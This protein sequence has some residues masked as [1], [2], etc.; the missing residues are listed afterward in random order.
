MTQLTA[1]IEKTLGPIVRAILK[2]IAVITTGGTI[3]SRTDAAGAQVAAVPGA[4]LLN[5]V[6]TDEG[7]IVEVRD[8]F[9]VNSYALTL[10][11]MDQ[12]RWAVNEALLEPQ[13]QGVV[14]A[15][16]TD[17]LEETA[18]LIELFHSDSRPVVFTG[19]Q[20]SAD[21]LGN[22]GP[23]NLE[24][25]IALAASP[26]AM[27]LGVLIMFDGI[28][29]SARGARKTHTTALAAFSDPDFGPLGHWERGELVLRSRPV[30]S[31]P[32]SFLT[33]DFT[34]VHVDIVSLYPGVTSTAMDAYVISGARGLVL[35]ATGTGNAN[36][37]IAAA[38]ARHVA[39]GVQ[40]V[41]STRVNAGPIRPVYGG[42]G[43]GH[44]LIAAGA[45]SAGYLRPSQARIQLAS[46]LACRASNDQILHSFRRD[47]H[48]TEQTNPHPT[49][50]S[51]ELS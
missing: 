4:D 51:K 48:R 38:V 29:H 26:A 44:D 28:V 27:D 45:I 16:G 24:D 49:T 30:R 2:R 41:L 25:A 5:S 20:R 15:H 14:V 34:D 50:Q 9:S 33:A 47:P 22:D 32:L 8:L 10:D 35:E 19:A 23:G 40:V 36:R 18:F 37:E 21:T 1:K 3:A 7:V 42:G 11:R 31:A 39:D 13:I 46:L 43:G 17:T 6:A 12:I